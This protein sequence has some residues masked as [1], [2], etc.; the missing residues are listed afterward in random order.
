MDSESYL[1]TEVQDFFFIGCNIYNIV[2]LREMRADERN[3]IKK[4]TIGAMLM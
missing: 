3:R 4:V 2:A 1:E